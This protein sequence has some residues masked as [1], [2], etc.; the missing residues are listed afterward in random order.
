M[1]D[2]KL[3]IIDWETCDVKPTTMV[4]SFGAT[5]FCANTNNTWEELEQ[6]SFYRVFDLDS[7]LK[8]TTSPN[9]IKWWMTQQNNAINAIVHPPEGFHTLYEG[10]TD[11]IEWLTQNNVTHLI[12][13]GSNFDNPILDDVFDSLHIKSPIPFWAHMD[14]RT[15]KWLYEQKTGDLNKLP[16]PAVMIPHNAKHDAMYETMCF[17]AY[18]KGLI[19]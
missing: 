6:Q 4:F 7:Q 12:G 3:A 14:L 2:N 5:F 17:Q 9:T 15:I 13:N 18:Y 11:F 16:Q 10:M 19:N 1:S 8:R